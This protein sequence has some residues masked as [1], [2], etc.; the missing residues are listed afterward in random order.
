[1][2]AETEINTVAHQ[3]ET[4]QFY[5]YIKVETEEEIGI[6]TLNRPEDKNVLKEE[7]RLELIKA[8]NSMEENKK[9]KAVIITGGPDIF[10]AGANIKAMVEAGAM[11]MYWRKRLPELCGIIENMPKPVIAAIGGYCFGGGTEIALS[12]DIRIAASNAKI[13]QPEIN[14]G[15]IPGGGGCVRL[16]RVVGRAKAKELIFTGQPVDAQEALR[17]GLVSQVV[18]PEEL[19]Q[20][21]KKMA[22][23]CA[24][25]SPVALHMAKVAIDV[26]MDLDRCSAHALEALAFCMNFAD[27]DQKEGMRAF[28]EKR[29]P[30]YKKR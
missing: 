13:G 22:Q 7:V 1:M 18:P 4:L 23:K 27:E 12:C 20:A 30:V 5:G 26:G 8:F 16:P 17:I 10:A 21:A 11:D 24:R 6:I 29:K 9:V 28:L 25:H 3:A 14:I 19:L 15:I 2:K